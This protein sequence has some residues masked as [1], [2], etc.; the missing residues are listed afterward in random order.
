MNSQ[1][2]RQKDE[3]EI[4][5]LYTEACNF[6]ETLK[7][8]INHNAKLAPRN[9]CTITPEALLC[10]VLGLMT[11]GAVKMGAQ[12]A[13]Q[14][15]GSELTFEIQP[16]G[17]SITLELSIWTK[18][19]KNNKSNNRFTNLTASAVTEKPSTEWGMFLLMIN[20]ICSA[21]IWYRVKTGVSGF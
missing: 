19:N 1:D 10:P 14:F 17:A 21:V 15:P 13:R 11:A 12:I 5:L 18:N 7:V 9:K 3:D 6:L 2:I 4:D 8:G 16:A 20:V